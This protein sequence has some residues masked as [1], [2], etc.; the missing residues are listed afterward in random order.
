ML[1]HENITTNLW[2]AQKTQNHRKETQ[3]TWILVVPL[4][5][6]VRR[7]YDNNADVL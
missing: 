7:V 1:S 4:D 5:H 3:K 2:P 6:N